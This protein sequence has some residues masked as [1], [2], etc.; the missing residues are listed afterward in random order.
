MER[1]AHETAIDQYRAA[2]RIA[3]SQPEGPERDRQEL[4]L[5]HAMSQPLNARYGFASTVLEAELEQ[6]LALAERLGDRRLQLLSLVGLFSTYVV[7]ARLKDSYD[8]SI[9]ALEGSHD[10][11]A[12]IGQAHFSVAGSAF[13]LGRLVEALEHFAVVPEL[14]LDQPLAVVGTRPEVHSE[15]WLSHALWLVDRVDEAHEHVEWAV[16][17][18]VELD[19]AFSLAVALAYQTMLAQFDERRADVLPL[20]E[21]TLALCSRHGFTYY[22]QWGRILG[23]WA[24]G[25]SKGRAAFDEGLTGLDALGALIRRPYY[26]T[27]RADLQLTDGDVQG[28]RDSLRLAHQLA[29]KRSDVWWLPEVLRR[30]AKLEEGGA[31]HALLQEAYDVAVAQGSQRLAN[32]VMGEPAFGRA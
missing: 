16:A 21:K 28:A 2:V 5:R 19:H 18:S 22:G 25:G 15:A 4:H 32:R 8:V 9:R 24:A 29:L 20:A 27:L 26:L 14:T 30:R 6:S 12:V 3:T 17:R 31:R 23:G 13:M 11:P 7:Q 1:Y 10:E